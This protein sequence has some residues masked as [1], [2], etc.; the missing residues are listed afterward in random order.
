M[1]SF[2]KKTKSNSN[3]IKKTPT[4]NKN[5]N[6]S[7][8]NSQ[9]SSNF[10]IEQE[11][12]TNPLT[13]PVTSIMQKISNTQDNNSLKESLGNVSDNIKKSNFSSIKLIMYIILGI[14]ILS[15]IGYNIFNY[16]AEGTDIIT[17]I[18]A[19][20]VNIIAMITGNTTK[21]T[22]D[23]TTTGSKTIVDGAAETGKTFIDNIQTG[24]VGGIDFIQKQIKDKSDKQKNKI[25][26]DPENNDKLNDVKKNNVDEE[27]EPIRTDTLN[28]GYCYVG[29]INDTRY[30]AK[31][32]GRNN[33][34][35]GDI[36]PSMDICVNPNLRA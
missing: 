7:N 27:P 29:K 21:T 33:C 19:P 36:Y 12:F 2:I 9:K 28:Q 31:V 32:S 10:Q 26:V 17:N 3:Y 34:M 35:S 6:N 24:S 20:F 14:L 5:F 8:T 16:L 23:N 30:C 25:I 11:K 13:K 15:F 4:S 22:I 18:T 1:E